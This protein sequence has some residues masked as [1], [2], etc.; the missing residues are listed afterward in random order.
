[1]HAIFFLLNLCF[2]SNIK[3][4]FKLYSNYIKIYIYY[5][6][7]FIH[8]IYVYMIYINNTQTTYDII[9]NKIRIYFDWIL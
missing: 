9:K 6:L 5:Y 2:N 3:F 7:I 4:K 8:G 1:M